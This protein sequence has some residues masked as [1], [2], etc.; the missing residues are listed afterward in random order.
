[1]KRQS[2][3]I[4]E[5]RSKDKIE[6]YKGEIKKLRKQVAQL[7][8]ENARLRNRDESFQEL[9]TEFGHEQDI[10]EET[11]NGSHSRFICPYCS[12]S[13]VKFLSLRYDNSHYNCNE[14]GKTGTLK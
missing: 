11:N 6:D 1:M 2:K 3:K 4:P 12:S 14:C 10:I 8:K 7:Q 13:N 5:E 9:I